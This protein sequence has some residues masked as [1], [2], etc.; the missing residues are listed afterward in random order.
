MKA[1]SIFK[2]LLIALMFVICSL[3][4]VF[5]ISTIN[6]QAAETTAVTFTHNG[7]DIQDWEGSLYRYLITVNV[8]HDIGGIDVTATV[9]KNGE[10]YKDIT[11][12]CHDTGATDTQY[13]II[14]IK[15][16]VGENVSRDA[17]LDTYKVT[18]KAGTSLG[19]NYHL[20]S[21]YSYVI[22]RGS[23]VESSTLEN[24]SLTNT[25]IHVQNGD[26][27]DVQRY[28]SQVAV[29]KDIKA[30]SGANSVVVT[31][32]VSKDNAPAVAKTF[33]FWQTSATEQ[34]F[35]MP[36]ARITGD[37]SVTMSAD[38]TNLYKITIKKGTMIANK[39]IVTE[40][41]S[42]VMWKNQA[43]YLPNVADTSVE[44][45]VKG[46]GEQEDLTRYLATIDSTDTGFVMGGSSKV[47]G[48]LDGNPALFELYDDAGASVSY[49]IIPYANIEAGKTTA[50]EIG[51]HRIIIPAGAQFGNKKFANTLVFDING[52]SMVSVDPETIIERKITVTAGENGTATAPAVGFWN[53]NVEVTVTPNEGYVVDTVKVNG[54]VQSVT[55]ADGK[56]TFVCPK[57]DANVEVTFKVMQTYVYIDSMYA[58]FTEIP[59]DYY[60]GDTFTFSIKPM[61]GFKF[62][63]TVVVK[64]NDV[65]VE[66]AE[67]V[68]SVVLKQEENVVTV[69][70]IEPMTFTVTYMDG[71]TVVDTLIV[72][73]Y[74]K[75]PFIDPP[76]KEG[77]EFVDWYLGDAPYN[78]AK[79]VTSDLT[80]TAVY[81]AITYEVTFKDGDT[82]VDTKTVAYNEAVAAIEA[83]AKEG[84]TFV[85]WYLG[86]EVYDFTAIVV[87]DLELT[88][89]YEADEP[90]V[91][92]EPVEPGDSEEP[93]EPG[94]SE[95]P[96]EP[97]DS[98]EPTDPETSDEASEDDLLAGCFAGIG[99][100]AIVFVALALCAV[101]VALRRKEN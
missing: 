39:F 29:D 10:Y 84:Y 3:C 33:D 79:P 76:E 47:M 22:N 86:E 16:L 36:Y 26:S 18:V 68:Y 69:E 57:A 23:F 21:D 65:V 17:I 25:A 100:T 71:E 91:P 28:Y 35:L 46:A 93:V 41:F 62:G 66:G 5:G 56:F 101:A 15:D 89:V 4:A 34:L 38:V 50:A 32:Q 19:A 53:Q 61:E 51:S 64:V 24:I 78:V 52:A 54:E 44:F 59:G 88:A 7:G 58:N 20:A 92:D 30:V 90:V 72:Q 11:V 37:A 42:Y 9:E 2:P 95:E 6:V 43:I 77:L 82:V 40:D 85:A 75:A 73:Y 31:A 83:P 94:D 96:V 80:L 74:K 87:E 55:V 14:L 1:K 63:E 70:G 48:T 98:E 81:E 8:D 12:G 27:V 49:L 97:G 99:E 45:E 13:F 67:G 60:Y